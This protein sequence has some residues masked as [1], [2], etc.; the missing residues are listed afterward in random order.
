MISRQ[1]R[2]GMGGS[3]Q[4]LQECSGSDREWQSMEVRT[5]PACEGTHLLQLVDGG[6]GQPK[7]VE[8]HRKLKLAQQTEQL[9]VSLCC[10]TVTAQAF[11]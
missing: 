5:V 10:Q 11:L 6:G 2:A 1:N 3:H 9:P 4:S 7:I 8:A